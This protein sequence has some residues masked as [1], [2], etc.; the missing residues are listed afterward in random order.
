MSDFFMGRCLVGAFVLLV[1][2]SAQAATYY[3]STAGSDTAAGT[4]AKPFLT[5]AKAQ[6]AATAGDTVYIRGGTYA[7]TGSGTGGVVFTKSG[8]AGAPISYFAYP[9]EVPVFDLSGLTPS[10]RVTGLD[11]HCDWVHLKGL[12]VTGVHQYASGQDSWGVRIRGSNNVIE[13]LNVHHNDAPGVFITSGANNLISNTDSH[14]NWDYLEGGGSGDGFGCHSSGGGNVLR[15][16]RS[17]D[18]SDDGFD[19]INAAGSCTV[20]RSWAFRNGYEPDTTT[21]AGNGAGFKSGGYGSPPVVPASG[22]AEHSVRQCVAFGNRA[23]GFY[24]NHHPGRINFFNN[25][26]FRNPANYNMLADAGYPSDHVIHNNVA[27]ATGS[28]ISNFTGGVATFNSWDLSVTVNAADFA[29]VTEALANTARSAD[30]SLPDIAL[31][32]LVAG[33]DLIDAGTDVG[34]SYAGEA[35]DLGAFEYGEASGGSSGSGGSGSGGGVGGGGGPSG[36]SSSGGPS[37]GSVGSAGAA[38]GGPAG[39]SPAAGG[40]AAAR[41]GAGGDDPTAPDEA[42]PGGCGCALGE[43]SS[44]T[45]FALWGLPLAVA[46]LRRRRRAS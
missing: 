23:E 25:T 6:T 15:G 32:H 20:E 38:S 33:S 35:P 5:V 36:G 13:N 24:A 19:F 28:S 17:F 45:T 3:V 9:G 11:V 43:S 21:A 37:G 40:A 44:G 4:L 42:Q 29:S 41:A 27:M 26:A 39:G 16:C 22:A 30:G 31:V 18:N 2:Q 12:E 46:F 10:N 14:H 8:A 34:L 1:G 7:F